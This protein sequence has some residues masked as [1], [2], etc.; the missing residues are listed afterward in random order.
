MDIE[1]YDTIC[2]TTAER[3]REAAELAAKCS[4]MLVVGG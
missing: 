2:D 3:Q 1:V 4:M